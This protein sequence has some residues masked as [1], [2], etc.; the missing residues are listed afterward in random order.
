MRKIIIISGVV[1]VVGLILGVAVIPTLKSSINPF[2]HSIGLSSDFDDKKDLVEFSERIVVAKY[3]GGDT[4]VIDMKNAYDGTVLGD[5]TLL[6]RRFE[7]I[8]SL[9]GDAKAGDMTYVA[10]ETADSLFGWKMPND[11]EY[12]QLSVGEDYVLFLRE[13][14]SL[15][16]FGDQYG[17]VV[18]AHEF[19]PSIAQIQSDTGDLRFKTTKRYRNAMDALSTSGAPFELSEERILALVSTEGTG[20]GTK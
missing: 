9:K 11:I 13:V 17:D 12:V 8:G 18:W 15:P 1:L 19:E 3:L 4:H 7:N 10:V 16:E 20:S 2:Y 6:V 14:A 5:I